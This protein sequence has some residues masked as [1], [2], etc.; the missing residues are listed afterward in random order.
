MGLP[1]GGSGVAV[2]SEP[3]EQP[4]D[5]WS[6]HRSRSDGKAACPPSKMEVKSSICCVT[7]RKE[8][9]YERIEKQEE[10]VRELRRAQAGRKYER[11]AGQRTGEKEEA[12]G[13]EM[14][15]RS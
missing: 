12:S 3:N 5:G 4:S 6:T 7:R 9:I 8:G 2:L 11:L 10:L 14:D 13:K 15:A 1:C